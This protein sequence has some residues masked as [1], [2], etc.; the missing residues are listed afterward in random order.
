MASINLKYTTI[1]HAPRR[2][3]GLTLV[4]CCVADTIFLTCSNP[5]AP[6]EGWC[7]YSKKQ[8]AEFVGITDRTVFQIINKLEDIGFVERQPVSGFVRTTGKW[9]NEFKYDV[10]QEDKRSERKPYAKFAQ[11][12]KNDDSYEESSD[13]PMKF[14]HT[15]YEEISHPPM[16]NLHTLNDNSKVKVNK[17]S[18]GQKKLAE[19][20]KSFSEVPDPRFETFWDVYNKKVKRPK[21]EKEWTKLTDR[22]KEVALERAAM[23]AEA[24]PEKQYR[25]NPDGWLRNK[26]WEDEIIKRPKAPQNPTGASAERLLEIKRSQGLA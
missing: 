8:I 20:E 11:G 2:K 9:F 1:Q 21:A 5:N 10:V 23:V 13:E 12:M 17:Q 4:E 3:H 6:V 7:S 19:R 24:I 26:G 14:L 22:Q 16:K 15:P 25:S 18:N